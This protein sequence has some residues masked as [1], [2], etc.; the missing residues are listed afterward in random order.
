MLGLHTNIIQLLGSDPEKTHINAVPVLQPDIEPKQIR[1]EGEASIDYV[2]TD[3][4]TLFTFRPQ[5]ILLGKDHELFE[6]SRIPLL[7]KLF[8]AW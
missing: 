3:S 8:L 7:Y 2:R 4:E 6:V 1:I 5:K